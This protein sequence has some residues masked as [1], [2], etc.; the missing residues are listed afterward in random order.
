[1]SEKNDFHSYKGQFI[2]NVGCTILI[3]VFMTLIGAMGIILASTFQDFSFI[4]IFFV[5]AIV[6]YPFLGYLIL[7]VLPKNNLLSVSI[8]S[9]L[10]A[11]I[12]FTLVI[13]SLLSGSYLGLISFVNFPA[14]M[15]VTMLIGFGGIIDFA[16]AEYFA[17]F[18]AAFIPSPL[19]YLGLR[20]RMRKEKREVSVA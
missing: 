3:H 11:V 4:A 2:A 16:Y 1:M 5:P 18:V 10:L 19:M 14:Y 6:G 9:L 17:F 15:I 13:G 7:Q 8:L 20:L 12:S